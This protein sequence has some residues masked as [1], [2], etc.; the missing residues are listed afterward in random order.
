MSAQD[1]DKKY[2]SPIDNFLRDFDAQHEKSKSQMKEI[3]K[4]EKI[5]RLRDDATAN[6]PDSEIWED[7]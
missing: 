1:I 7:F 4:H 2:V 3:K 6:K 5:A